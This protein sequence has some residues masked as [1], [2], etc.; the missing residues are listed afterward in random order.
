MQRELQISAQMKKPIV[1]IVLA[2]ATLTGL[3]PSQQVFELDPGNPAGTE[4]SIMRHL[5]TLKLSKGNT[6]SLGALALILVGLL[7]LA[8]K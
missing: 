1:P 2:G 8:K 7:I 6:A 4:D 3:Q 5:E